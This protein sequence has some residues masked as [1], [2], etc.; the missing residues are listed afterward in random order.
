MKWQE[1]VEE[2]KLYRDIEERIA[3]EEI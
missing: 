3:S 2:S 1:G